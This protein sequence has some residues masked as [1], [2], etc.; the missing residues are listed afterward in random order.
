MTRFWHKKTE[1]LKFLIDSPDGLTPHEASLRFDNVDPATC[2]IALRRLHLYG[3]A[4][5]F[6][7]YNTHRYFVTLKGRDRYVFLI[8]RE[9]AETDESFEED[10]DETEEDVSEQDVGELEIFEDSEEHEE[11]D[12]EYF[13]EVD[14]EEMN[15][16]ELEEEIA[17]LRED[18]EMGA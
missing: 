17:E 10:Q 9:E 8:E 15:L 11:E 12:L 1:Y 2:Y 13:E 7:E 4:K 14:P 18:L 16:E 5:R 6:T 3:L